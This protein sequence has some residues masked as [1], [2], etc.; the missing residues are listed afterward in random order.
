MENRQYQLDQ[1]E[2]TIEE[3]SAKRKVLV[4]LATGGGKCLGWNTPVLMYDGTFKNVQDIF[5]GEQLMGIDS[6]PR[7]VLSTT[8]GEDTMYKITPLKGDWFCCNESHILSL[9][10]NSTQCGLIKDNT[11]NFS[12]KEYLNLS[13]TQKHILK[14]YKSEQL[15]FEEKK[16]SIPSYILG[17]WLG[18]GHSRSACI[19]NMDTEVINEWYM[20]AE[21]TK[22]EIRVEENRGSCAQMHHITNQYQKAGL[23]TQLQKYNLIENK[24][25]PKEYL[26]NT[27][28]HRMELLAGLID[29]DG[30]LHHNG[31]EIFC[32][33]ENLANDIIFLCR[34]LGFCTKRVYKKGIN[35]SRITFYGKGLEKI[36]LRLKFKKCSERTQ[37]KDALRT[38]FKVEKIGIGDYYGFEIDGDRLF[39]INEDLTVTHNTVE[40]AI[41][42]Q[43]F[44]RNY[45]SDNPHNSVLILVHREELLYQAQRTIKEVLDID[46]CLITS[47]SRH[48]RIARV[49]IGMVESTISRL[50]LFHNIGLVIIDECHIQNFNKVHSIFLEELIIGFS[51]TPLS[52][53]KKDPLRNYYRSIITGPQIKE[54]IAMGYLA[55]S[56]TR[57]PK[58]VVDVRKFSVNPTDGDYRTG[59]MASEY[60][61]P[62]YV[63]N[64][65]EAYNQFCY[66]KKTL[67]FNVNIEHSKEV[68][69]C[70]VA[71]G[72]NCRHLA[73][74]NNSERAEVLKWFHDTED[75]ILCNVMMF[76]FGFDEPTILNI[77]SNFSTLSLPK[78]IQAWGRGS[79]V[80]DEAFIEKWQHTYPYKLQPKSHFN[81]IDMGGNSYDPNTKMVK[82]GDWSDERDWAR[83]FHNSFIPGDGIAPVKSCPKCDGLVH[84]AS[85]ICT[86]TDAEGELCL[87][88]FESKPRAVEQGLRE[89]M[90]ITKGID[91]EE[92]TGKAK[93]KYAYYEMNEMADGVVANM[94]TT[95]PEPTKT[96]VNRY[97]RTYY[98][99]CIKWYNQKMSSGV[100]NISD[101][102]NSG[103]HI[104]KAKHN[105]NSI[106]KKR[107]YNAP[108]VSDNVEI[109]P[110]NYDDLPLLAMR[111]I[112]TKEDDVY[113]W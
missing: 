64:V 57:V 42:A 79:R 55:Q 34:S 77:I 17:I 109:E 4:Q 29:T 92:I 1:V 58:D 13:V 40:F 65:V 91:I 50:D 113:E 28:A 71:C 62:R 52:A 10:C 69:S 2:K 89:M 43:R 67:I 63:K 37:I 38:Q 96:I 75:A 54:L 60:K 44:I 51:A 83:I 80:I 81:I 99:L 19:T 110:I 100:N 68:A 106:L 35:G 70:F 101:I 107:N 11:Y 84:A 94:L 53:N 73:S 85:R 41:I 47:E 26:Y 7:N 23:L 5:E 74:D 22:Q 66:G 103:W 33:N 78:A 24:H 49:Y 61:L 88:E 105:F 3:V 25:I 31:Y 112:P 48:F 104:R 45:V 108:S 46:A 93:N 111:Y 82:F 97:F 12:I 9:K 6:T 59:E 21:N 30:H 15:N 90:V 76:T 36:P 16:V 14:L 18:D 27:I 87:H 20:Y 8:S 72:F 86:L 32:L 39:I 95:F 98:E 56:I 102:S